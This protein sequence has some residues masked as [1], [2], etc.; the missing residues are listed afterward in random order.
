MRC[1]RTYLGHFTKRVRSR[2]GWMSPP[3]RKF[4]GAFSKSGFLVA[5][6]PFDAPSGAA[7]TFFPPFAAA[8]LP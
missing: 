7:A 3:R 1:K 6:L 8:F 5:F 4:L 2:L